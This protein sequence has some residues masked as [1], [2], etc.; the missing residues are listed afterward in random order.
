MDLDQLKNVWQKTS[1]EM[2]E[3]YFISEQNMHE[4]IQKK[5]NTTI[6]KVKR[7]MKQKVLYAGTVS[8]LM[9]M[10]SSFGFLREEPLFDKISN[11]E[12]GIFYL[13]FGL[14]IAFISI[15]NAFSYHKVKQ[16]EQY[17]SDLKSSITSVVK[18]LKSAMNAKIFS[19]TF[20][21]PFT[22]IVLAIVAYIRGIGAFTNPTL[23][24]YSLLVSIGL[25]ILSY[26]ISKKG[27]CSRY[28]Q[29][30]I[31]LE[32]SLRELEEEK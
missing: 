23:I 2:G 1:G 8:I 18:V 27:Q 11:I 13:I 32:E 20:V 3:G 25:G 21:M 12:A 31:S 19:D 14:V 26:F 9:I 6:A 15:F 29:Q 5:S 7:Q 24:F 10:F 17:E 30:M 16:I 28:E 22:V 4:L